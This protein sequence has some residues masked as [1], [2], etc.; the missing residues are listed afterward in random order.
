MDDDNAKYNDR[1][2]QP[3]R[4]SELFAEQWTSEDRG[5][6]RLRQQRGRNK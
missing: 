6:N 3:F 5:E 2:A 4:Q 1:A